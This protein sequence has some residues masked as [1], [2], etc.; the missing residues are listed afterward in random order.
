MRALDVVLVAALGCFMAVAYW[1]PYWMLGLA[2]AAVGLALRHRFEIPRLFLLP[3][4]LVSSLSLL[5]LPDELSQGS[6][7]VGPASVKVAFYLCLLSAIGLIRKN[8]PDEEPVIAGVAIATVGCCGLVTVT[9]NY[10][11]AIGFFLLAFIFFS[12]R[13]ASLKARG[14][15]YFLIA[16]T[17]LVSAGL[18]VVLKWSDRYVNLLTN[19]MSSPVAAG[20]RFPP[21]SQLRGMLAWQ[22]SSNL[23]LRVFAERPN[24][25]LVGRTYAEYDKNAWHWKAAKS[26]AEKSEP[27]RGIPQACATFKIGPLPENYKVERLEYPLVSNATTF[28]LPRDAVVLG[29]D[30][31]PVHL[32]DDGIYFINQ[33]FDGQVYYARDTERVD[34]P[35]QLTLTEKMSFLK[36]PLYLS[37][38]V[39][40]L[41]ESLTEGVKT[42]LE[43]ARVLEK[44]LQENFTYGFGYPFENDEDPIQTFLTERPPAHCEFFAS[45][46]V[47]MLR[48]LGV[49]SRY[50]TGF[51]VTE[52]S[53]FDDYYVVRAK[54]AHAWVEVHVEGRGWVQ[55]DPTPPGSLAE[56]NGWI[57][58][59]HSLLEYLRYQLQGFTGWFKLGWM[60][61][62]KALL[63]LAQRGFKSPWLWLLVAAGVFYLFWRRRE[64]GSPRSKPGRLVLEP[65]ELDGL[66][67]Q[68][69]AR[70]PEGER[71]ARHQTLLEWSRDFEPE[72]WRRRFSVLYCR[73]RYGEEA[74]LPRL[75]ELLELRALSGER[76]E[77]G[78]GGRA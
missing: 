21:S 27:V 35:D 19:L 52:K 61:K 53:L 60:D 11:L 17:F 46:L 38:A 26:N 40:E 24:R 49:P 70:L 10:A 78:G 22:S 59:Y 54:H 77:N 64:P 62:L 72:D 44:Y 69:E 36:L 48:H 74:E 55:F 67:A 5:L 65:D 39:P 8:Q 15:T 71:R 47:L 7:F 32:Y 2:L 23:V 45:S 56:G 9:L 42:P 13:G 68:F 20:I 25:Y 51:I 1:S 63:G 28:F 41:A 33:S 31:E 75:R 14:A 73:A 34:F 29:V 43:Q 4:A 3:A 16:G 57:A 66:L 76:N 12:C 6:Q 58:R 30:A 18:A 50:V 37:P